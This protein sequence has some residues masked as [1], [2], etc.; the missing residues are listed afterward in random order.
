M[1]EALTVQD[2]G[3]VAPA[4]NCYEHAFR[5]QKCRYVDE[6]NKVCSAIKS[7]K[8]RCAEHQAE[9]DKFD[10]EIKLEKAKREREECQY[11]EDN[12]EI[13]WFKKCE[14]TKGLSYCAIHLEIFAQFEIEKER[15]RKWQKEAIEAEIPVK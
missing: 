3:V 2:N 9:V 6:E 10:A 14:N 12:D 7:N 1:S 11:V 13:C 4:P 8:Y 15:D 5:G